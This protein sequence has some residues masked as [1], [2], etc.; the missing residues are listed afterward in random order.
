MRARKHH[1]ALHYRQHE[2]RQPLAID[3]GRQS[4]RGLFQTPVHRRGP[5]VEIL[6]QPPMH[7]L[8]LRTDL[9]RQ[10]ADRTAV[11]ALGLQNQ[12]AIASQQRK[13]P[14]TNRREL[15]IDQK[16][17]EDKAIFSLRLKG[18]K[19]IIPNSIYNGEKLANYLNL[20]SIQSPI[21]TYDGFSNLKYNFFAV[22]T[23]LISGN[24]VIF[25][26]GS[27]SQAMRAS[28]SVTFLLPPV[29]VDSL[30]LDRKRAGQAN[31]V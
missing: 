10:P 11:S 15:F 24:P 19:P 9:Q 8:L 20:L 5:S 25:N 13:Y 21:H 18:L 28:S 23:D 22:S 12:D 1:A 30:T 29:K 6:R 4:I 7:F 31:S 14:E 17:T 16:I 2:S 27:I 26:S 3:V